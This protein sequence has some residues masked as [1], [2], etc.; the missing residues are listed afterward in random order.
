MNRQCTVVIHG[1]RCTNKARSGSRSCG[2]HGHAH[3]SR[4]AGGRTR[5]VHLDCRV[6]ALV[7]ELEPLDTSDG[8]SIEIRDNGALVGLPTN[9]PQ[10]LAFLLDWLSQPGHNLDLLERLTPPSLRPDPLM[11]N[12]YCRVSETL[13]RYD[14][15]DGAA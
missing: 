14:R 4:S 3:A 15:V 8:I 11:A 2:Q 5:F 7:A 1:R 9:Q 13:Y 12:T 10:L 6:N